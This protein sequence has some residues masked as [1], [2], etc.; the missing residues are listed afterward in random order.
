MC[1]H[2]IAPRARLGIGVVRGR[3][4]RCKSKT[5]Y[6]IESAYENRILRNVMM[7]LRQRCSALPA[8]CLLIL[9]HHARSEASVPPRRTIC[10]AVQE[11][12]LRVTVRGMY[13]QAA[14]RADDALVGRRTFSQTAA[15]RSYDDTIKNLYIRPDTKVLCQG[16]T[17]KTVRENCA[18]PCSYLCSRGRPGY[19][20]CARGARLRDEHG[21]RRV[22][23]QG[24]PDTSR[25][26][27]VRFGEGG[28][29]RLLRLMRP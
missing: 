10:S 8:R 3:W 14:L 2:C 5:V 29:P 19:F 18:L 4:M 25:S 23:E 24:W 6:I 17:G 21:R 11:N 7:R 1:T 16:F 22:P 13:S 26:S 20:P 9:P 12:R 15:R 28:T 27:R